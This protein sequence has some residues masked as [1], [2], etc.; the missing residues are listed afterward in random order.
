VNLLGHQ[1]AAYEIMMQLFTPETCMQSETHRKITAWY[2]RFDIMAGLMSGN[3]TTL[4]REWHAAASDFHTQRARAKPD[5]LPVGIAAAFA[6]SRLLATDISL[7]F[8]KKA[9]GLMTDE[10]F[11]VVLGEMKQRLAETE[12]YFATAF[13]DRRVYVKDFPPPAEGEVENDVVDPRDPNFVLTGD[14]WTWNFVLLDFW[15]LSVMFKSQ[16]AQIDPTV[17]I[18]EAIDAA[19]NVGKMYEALQLTSKDPKAVTLGAQASV[20]IAATAMPKDH[21]HIMWCRRK[22]AQIE[23][24]GY[25]ATRP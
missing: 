17:D 5:D 3:E 4:S 16:L 10:E 2:I 7:V 14:M 21:K 24:C 25:V 20:G 22:Y 1:K 13:S 6:V 15:G 18:Q 12:H 9:K 11:M 8:G 19:H 23:T